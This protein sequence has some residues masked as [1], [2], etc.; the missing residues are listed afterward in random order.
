MESD[1]AASGGLLADFEGRRHL[2]HAVEIG[3]TN[4]ISADLFPGCERF[5]GKDVGPC[6]LVQTEILVLQIGPDHVRL[7][8]PEAF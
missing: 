3:S 1:V 6:F 8:A 5:D 2:D 7:A 4:G